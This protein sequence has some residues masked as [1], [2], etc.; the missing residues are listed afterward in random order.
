LP[1]MDLFE[2][3]LK[4]SVSQLSDIKFPATVAR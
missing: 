1:V 2:P 4:N 3:W